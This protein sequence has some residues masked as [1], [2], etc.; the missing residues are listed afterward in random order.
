MPFS[1]KVCSEDLVII[2]RC[3]NIFH[4]KSKLNTLSTAIYKAEVQVDVQRL[5]TA[6]CIPVQRTG[7]AR[8]VGIPSAKLFRA[9]LLFKRFQTACQDIQ[10][11]GMSED[12]EKANGMYSL[13]DVIVTTSTHL[14]S[15]FD[16]V[17][18]IFGICSIK[19]LKL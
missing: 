9:N 17:L 7:D 2:L 4:S 3:R 11:S 8:K 6:H 12:R 5:P 13:I 18:N 16:Q 19:L 10:V 15:G 14:K 1:L